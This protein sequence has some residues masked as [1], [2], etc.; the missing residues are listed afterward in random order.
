MRKFATAIFGKFEWDVEKDRENFL[1]H[2]LDF[3]TASIAFLDP[4]RIIA[5]DE[6]HSLSEERLFCVGRIGKRIATVRFTR[7]RDRIRII[8]AGFWRS[9]K[10]LYEKESKR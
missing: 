3:Y 6:K 2:D 5:V 8:G 10:K 7:R 9:G 1:K 4:Q